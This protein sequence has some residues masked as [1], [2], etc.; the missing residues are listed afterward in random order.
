MLVRRDKFSNNST[1]VQ[2]ANTHTVIILQSI[3]FPFIRY[4]F[5]TNFHVIIPIYLFKVLIKRL[6]AFNPVEF[7]LKTPA[8]SKTLANLAP[9]SFCKVA[10]ASSRFE[11][12]P[13]LSFICSAQGAW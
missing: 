8:S 6:N 10:S 5:L 7:C 2:K 13:Y 4:F 1:V 12:V 9:N 3:F 11:N